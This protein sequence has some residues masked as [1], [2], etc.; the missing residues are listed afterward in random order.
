MP[1]SQHGLSQA[2]LMADQG[3]APNHLHI[4]VKETKASAQEH[5]LAGARVKLEAPWSG[6]RVLVSVAIMYLDT[7]SWDADTGVTVSLNIICRSHAHW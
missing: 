1:H 4:T 2:I 5:T 3:Q 7:H 6:P